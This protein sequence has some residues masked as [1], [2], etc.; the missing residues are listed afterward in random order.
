[1]TTEDHENTRHLPL[2]HAMPENVAQAL[3]RRHRKVMAL[4]KVLACEAPEYL[5]LAMKRQ[6]D[7]AIELASIQAAAFKK[8]DGGETR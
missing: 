1:M 3:G 8:R 6:Q 7:R 5:T 4:G 2:I